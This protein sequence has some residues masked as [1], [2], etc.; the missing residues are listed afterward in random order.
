MM[1]MMLKTMIITFRNRPVLVSLPLFPS[2]S[3]D[4]GL[5]P[6]RSRSCSISCCCF[7][8]SSIQ[9]WRSSSSCLRISLRFLSCSMDIWINLATSLFEASF[10]R[11]RTNLEEDKRTN[12]DEDKRTNLD[13]DKRTNL[14]EDKRKWLCYSVTM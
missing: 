14:D 3:I 6:C 2:A 10:S 13:E 12:H 8:C 5:V 11:P 7:S 1:I 9:R 4:C